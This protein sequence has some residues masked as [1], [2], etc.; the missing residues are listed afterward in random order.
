MTTFPFAITEEIQLAYQA[1][2]DYTSDSDWLVENDPDGQAEQALIESIQSALLQA[3]QDHF[4]DD[5]LAE[6]DFCS[7]FEVLNT[8]SGVWYDIIAEQL[9]T[10]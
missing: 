5:E 2:T 8:T 7:E 4:S 10:A 3:A 6:S 1:H 9:E